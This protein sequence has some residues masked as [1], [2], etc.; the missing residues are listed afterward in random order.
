LE[1]RQPEVPASPRVLIARRFLAASSFQA[2]LLAAFVLPS[3]GLPA[4]LWIVPETPAAAAA[5][6]LAF[7]ASAALCLL[8]G[9]ACLRLG[10]SAGFA[11]ALFLEFGR[12]NG[13]SLL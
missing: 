1:P 13:D 9:K 4:G 6:S 3:S 2:I 8:L 11:L 10:T 7:L 12:L 5:C